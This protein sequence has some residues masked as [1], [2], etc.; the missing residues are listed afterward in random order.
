VIKVS[1]ILRSVSGSDVE[2]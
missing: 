1:F 2:R